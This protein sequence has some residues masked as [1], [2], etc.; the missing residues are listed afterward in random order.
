MLLLVVPECRSRLLRVDS[1]P[2]VCTSE[3]TTAPLTKTS[4]SSSV[5][6]APSGTLGLREYSPIIE[7]AP[8]GLFSH[9]LSTQTQQCSASTYKSSRRYLLQWTT[10]RTHADVISLRSFLR[11]SRSNTSTGMCCHRRDRPRW[12]SSCFDSNVPEVRMCSGKAKCAFRETRSM[13]LVKKN[14]RL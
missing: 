1:I 8:S 5:L 2:D 3:G 6:K 10:Q 14:E 7:T 12:L 11:S 9:L 13:P 4:S